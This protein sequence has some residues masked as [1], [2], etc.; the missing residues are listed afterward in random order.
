MTAYLMQNALLKSDRPSDLGKN[1]SEK[2]SIDCLQTIAQLDAIQQNW[3]QVYH[4]DD[5]TTVFTSWEWLRGNFDA[6]A[7]DLWILAVRIEDGPEYVGFLPLKLR[8]VQRFGIVLERR[9]EMMGNYDADYTGFICLP[10]YEAQVLTACARYL[11]TNRSWHSLTLKDILDPRLDAFVAEI[12]RLTQT[13]NRTLNLQVETGTVSPFV[14]FPGD[15][16]TYLMTAVKGPY[17]RKIRNALKKLESDPALQI[18]V[19]DGQN[20]DL[21]LTIFFRMHRSQWQTYT[22]ANQAHYQRFYRECFDQ[23]IL[24]LVVLYQDETPIAADLFF[25]DTK[26]G[27]LGV[28]GRTYDANFASLAPGHINLC[29]VIRESLLEGLKFFDFLRGDEGYKAIFG[30]QERWTRHITILRSRRSRWIRQVQEQVQQFRDRKQAQ[31]LTTPDVK[32]PDVKES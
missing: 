4:Q 32:A 5:H 12:Q 16:E 6:T 13:L 30:S 2:I 7:A 23:G 15:W 19:A 3:T 1:P 10:E 22:D 24:R 25:Y 8:S 18:V 29:Y 28:Y 21:H 27:S 26:Q 9:L 17:R 31:A 11:V 20:F 14:L